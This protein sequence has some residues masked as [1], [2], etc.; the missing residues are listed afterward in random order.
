MFINLAVSSF[1]IVKL[2][3]Y[4]SKPGNKLDPRDAGL[5]RP[6]INEID[7]GIPG[8]VGYPNAF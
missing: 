8:V 2:A 7:Y 3:W 4:N 1:P 6:I 5:F